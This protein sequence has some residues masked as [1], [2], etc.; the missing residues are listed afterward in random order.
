MSA[1]ALQEALAGARKPTC[2]AGA[3][4]PQRGRRA[5][6]VLQHIRGAAPA[7]DEDDEDDAAVISRFA[8]SFS[9]RTMES[10]AHAVAEDEEDDEPHTIATEQDEEDETMFDN[11]VAEQEEADGREL[12]ALKDA[13]KLALDAAL[14]QEPALKATAIAWEDVGCEDSEAPAWGDIGGQENCCS[15]VPKPVAAATPPLTAV[16]W[17]SLGNDADDLLEFCVR[18]K[19]EPAAGVAWESLGN[20]GEEAPSWDE[21]G[22]EDNWCIPRPTGASTAERLPAVAWESLGNDADDLWE[23]CVAQQDPVPMESGP[24]DLAFME[25]GPDASML[26]FHCGHFEEAKDPAPV[27]AGADDGDADFAE[28]GASMLAFHCE[29]F[30]EVRA[31]AAQR[32]AQAAAPEAAKAAPPTPSKTRRRILR[33]IPTLSPKAVAE[34]PASA[35]PACSPMSRR[36]RQMLTGSSSMPSLRKGLKLSSVDLLD[37]PTEADSCWSRALLAAPPATAQPSWLGALPASEG[38]AMAHDLGLSAGPLFS[39]SRASRTLPGGSAGLLPQLS[40]SPFGAKGRAKFEQVPVAGQRNR[41]LWD[42]DNAFVA[43]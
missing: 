21:L 14:G 17:E 20:D 12:Q 25:D 43:S 31:E 35:S 22:A 3:R 29:H 28:V 19:E 15:T 18:Q 5:A 27:E 42:L 37:R 1:A 26:T 33:D 2:D 40:S 30:D 16:A 32:A 11:M 7:L 34:A 24:D 4:R 8:T 36:S 38:S 41:R 39:P 6:H 13:A 9:H 23:A 10:A